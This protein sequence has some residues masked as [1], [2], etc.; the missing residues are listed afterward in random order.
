MSSH[1]PRKI[2]TGKEAKRDNPSTPDGLNPRLPEIKKQIQDSRLRQ[3]KI[4]NQIKEDIKK[5]RESNISVVGIE[6][7]SLKSIVKL[8]EKRTKSMSDVISSVDNLN[9]LLKNISKLETKYK[10]NLRQSS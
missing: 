2:S 4:I 8:Q 9:L 10:Q 5:I 6:D 3:S 7:L 1:N